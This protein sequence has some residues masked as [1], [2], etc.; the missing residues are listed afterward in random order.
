MTI[1]EDEQPTT[2]VA[3]PGRPRRSWR[4]RVQAARRGVTR[5][6]TDLL[7]HPPQ[8]PQ[9]WLLAAAGLLAGLLMF[10][11][12]LAALGWLVSA[13]LDWLLGEDPP[14]P[15]P[16]PDPAPP[17][18]LTPEQEATLRSL[19]AVLTEPVR[20]YF[21]ARAHALPASADVLAPAWGIGGLL[22]VLCGW[23]GSWGA[24]IGWLVYGVATGL[25]V[26]HGAHPDARGPALA[27]AALAWGLLSTLA[28]TGAWK[29][30]EEPSKPPE[31][32]RTPRRDESA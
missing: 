17:E 25:I 11:A 14:P 15:P 28:F 10:V 29:R 23:A 21:A 26:W 27:F 19:L 4:E 32:R 18:L 13:L 12:I 7:G 8:G 1:R 20:T 22:L 3:P 6:C 2:E 24:R 9:D 30:A 31:L 5:A 16:E